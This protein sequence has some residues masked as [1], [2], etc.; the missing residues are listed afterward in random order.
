MSDAKKPF[1]NPFAVLAERRAELPPGEA[2]KTPAATSPDATTPKAEVR[3]PARAVV[4][5]ERK[6]RR[7]KEVTVVEHL[8]LPATELEVW[9]KA[10]KAGLGCGGVVEGD[11]LA[12][13]GDQRTRVEALLVS[14]GVRKI[15][16]A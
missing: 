1:N 2:A 5:L 7:G 6:G 15:T 14:R 4:R 10:L 11:A 13:Q 9:L 3:G 8:G 16:I 12:L